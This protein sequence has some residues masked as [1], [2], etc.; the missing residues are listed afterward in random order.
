MSN[1]GRFDKFNDQ[2]RMVLHYAQ[3]EAQRLEHGYIGTEHLLL[4][5]VHEENNTASTVLRALGIELAK[6]RSAVEIIIARGAKV[7]TAQTGLTRRSKKV[8]EL[9]VD[10]ARRLGY[11]YISTEHMLLG[12][13]REGEGIGASVLES[14]GVNLE[15]V[16]MKVAQISPDAQQQQTQSTVN[17]PFV[18][19]TEQLSDKPGSE[20]IEASRPR[21]AAIV[22]T[23]S[24]RP[25]AGYPF[26]EQ[27]HRVIERAHEEA[28]SFQHNYIGTEHLLLGLLGNNESIASAVLQNLGLELKRLRR[29][30]EFIIGR[31]DRI[32]LGEIG[33]TPRAK[34][35]LE[36]AS[37]EAQRM[38]SNYVGTEHI[39][40]GMIVEGEG[41]AA[42]ILESQGINLEKVRVETKRVLQ[43]AQHEKTQE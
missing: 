28:I 26:T 27:S 39:L 4:G 1:T 17:E 40:L 31:G 19:Q 11:H 3:E 7:E 24:M 42:G 16:R 33:L 25:Y 9:A 10:E 22:Q 15:K 5:L 2:A 37:K 41:I 12:L 38:N 36:L 14:Q 21:N 8:I 13:L 43:Y 23:Q 6:I 30:V 35:L 18:E 32:V 29:D 20:K 34:K